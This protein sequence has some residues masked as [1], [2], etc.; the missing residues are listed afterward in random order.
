[1]C[2]IYALVSP[3]QKMNRPNNKGQSKEDR[4]GRGER[5]SWRKSRPTEDERQ[6]KVGKGGERE[7]KRAGERHY[8]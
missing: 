1:M 5:K 8:A 6:K 4:D 7:R 3:A 2:G